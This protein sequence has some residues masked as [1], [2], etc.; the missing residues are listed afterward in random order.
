MIIIADEIVISTHDCRVCTNTS[1]VQVFEDGYIHDIRFDN[2]KIVKMVFQLIKE[3]IKRQSSSCRGE[4]VI[5]IS[6]IRE[7]IKTKGD[8]HERI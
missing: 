4:V 1:C 7:G 3:E 6:E 2:E 5:D 8:K